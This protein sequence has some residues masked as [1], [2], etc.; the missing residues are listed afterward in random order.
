[1]KSDS[2]KSW[3]SDFRYG[4]LHEASDAAII[5]TV[6]GLVGG[7]DG[8]CLR[9]FFD[10]PVV[11]L[12]ILADP[13]M[14]Q[15]PNAQSLPILK[16]G[17]CQVHVSDRLRNDNLSAWDLLVMRPEMKDYSVS[18]RQ[19]IGDFFGLLRRY[20]ENFYSAG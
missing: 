7:G 3:I 16:L 1:M 15:I 10:P 5:G 2:Q 19:Q 14:A 9:I 18:I 17:F 6:I 12:T 4:K 20:I 13:G 8:P 11:G